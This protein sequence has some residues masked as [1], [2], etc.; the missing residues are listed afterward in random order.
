MYYIY[1]NT[2]YLLSITDVHYLFDNASATTSSVG[3]TQIF[4]LAPKSWGVTRGCASDEVEKSISGGMLRSLISK[5]HVKVCDRY[6]YETQVRKAQSEKVEID[7]GIKG[8]NAQVNHSF[9][10]LPKAIKSSRLSSLLV[11]DG[12]EEEVVEEPVYENVG[13]VNRDNDRLTALE[14]KFDKMCG[15]LEQ[16]V[17][18]ETKPKKKKGKK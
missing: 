10:F 8:D 17:N 14:N 7:L 9:G 13:D 12:E 2:D 18:K 4:K 3:I 1:N 6:E 5:G 15:I 16:L 11:S